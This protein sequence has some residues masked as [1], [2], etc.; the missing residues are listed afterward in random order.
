MTAT[1]ALGYGLVRLAQTRPVKTTCKGIVV[2]TTGAAL[3]GL[4]SGIGFTSAGAVVT[5][6]AISAAGA[7]PLIGPTLAELAGV[8]AGTTSVLAPVALVA[9]GV[10]CLYKLCG[11]SDEKGVRFK[12]TNR[13]RNA[14]TRVYAMPQ[15]CVSTTWGD[16]RLCTNTLEHGKQNEIILPST[17]THYKACVVFR[18]SSVVVFPDVFVRKGTAIMVAR[19]RSIFHWRGEYQVECK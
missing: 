14:I 11:S 5:G 13:S 18:D 12:I 19:P 15:S 3:G 8:I 7:V 9:G 4:L 10:W 6:T 16:N 2:G 17:N 1:T